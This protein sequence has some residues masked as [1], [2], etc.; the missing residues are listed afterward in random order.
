M[1]R[2]KEIRKDIW[3]I[4]KKTYSLNE[5]KGITAKQDE[6][7]DKLVEYLDTNLSLRRKKI[8]DDPN[9]KK[10]DC[11]KSAGSDFFYK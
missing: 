7:L 10:D 8:K 5:E 2:K 9:D 11:F 6:F 3:E 1:D 4:F